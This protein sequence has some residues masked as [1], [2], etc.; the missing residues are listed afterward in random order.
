MPKTKKIRGKK[1]NN[2]GKSRRF[3]DILEGDCIFP[4]IYQGKVF[5]DCIPDTKAKKYNGSR[6][7]TQVDDVGNLEKWGYCPKSKTINKTIKSKGCNKRNPSPPCSNGMYEKKRPNGTLCCYKGEDPNKQNLETKPKSSPQTKKTP[8][9][10]KVNT[11]KKRISSSK[12]KKVSMPSELSVNSLRLPKWYDNSCF[13]DSVLVCLFLRPNPYLIN[14][15][16]EKPITPF[17]LSPGK[18]S[19]EEIRSRTLTLNSGC[20][21]EGRMKIRE[22]LLNIFNYIHNKIDNN[23]TIDRKSKIGKKLSRRVRN[24]RESMKECILPTYEDFTGKRVAEANEFLKYLFSMF[25]D[26]DAPNLLETTYFTNDIETEIDDIDD[27]SSLEG[28]TCVS[29]TLQKTDVYFFVSP[30]DIFN[31][32]GETSLS[33]FLESK[34]D[35]LRPEN[36]D[37]VCEEENYE[38]AIKFRELKEE[39]Y[40]IFDLSRSFG[41]E[42]LD[43]TI[44]PDEEIELKNGK[45]FKFVSAVYRTPGMSST[46][47]T[48]FVLINEIW[49]AYDDNPGGK[50]PDLEE[51]GDYVDLLGQKIMECVMYFYEPI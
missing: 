14:R 51:I 38:R 18:Y 15:F 29:E 8:S 3:H 42:Y 4:F 47:F 23:K 2:V 41:G 45:K 9:P 50:N 34:E 25:P 48:S 19:E 24:F 31:A 39:R 37:F 26:E 33:D 21:V 6:C 12:N 22:Q 35:S 46:H 13:M 10:P 40:L 36:S 44:I 32:S 1:Q 20:S 5:N 16:L 11:K 49:Y 43:N 30:S 7:A 27:I 28:D 17:V